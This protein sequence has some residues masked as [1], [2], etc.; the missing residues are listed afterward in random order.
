MNLV[1]LSPALEAELRRH[2]EEQYP[3]EACGALIGDGDG[4]N[5]PWQVEEIRLASNMHD[6]D[7]KR[8]YL[9]PPDFQAQVEKY[10]RETGRDVVGFYH[11]HPDHSAD[12]SEYDRTHAW[13]G[14]L[15]VICSVREGKSAEIRSLTL[16]PSGFFADATAHG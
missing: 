5:E 9:I 14:Y 6:G 4:E 11:S 16:A 3:H 15:Y 2:C 13:A 10:A 7:H 12:P 8:R 1:P